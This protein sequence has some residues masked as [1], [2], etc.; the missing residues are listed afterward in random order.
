MTTTSETV[1]KDRDKRN[2][3]EL[4]ATT[5]PRVHR[6]GALEYVPWLSVD[7]ARTSV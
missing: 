6:R 1:R 7:L 2:L 3:P 4:D 5:K